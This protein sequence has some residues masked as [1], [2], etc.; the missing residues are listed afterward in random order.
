MRISLTILFNYIG[1]QLSEINT[2]SRKH[3]R[4]GVKRG[5]R[6][7]NVRNRPFSY[8]D[9]AYATHT[10]THTHQ[11]SIKI[12]GEENDDTTMRSET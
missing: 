12:H 8:C 11:K 9:A 7:T 3:T 5:L 6:D 2:C 4:I 1:L 10:S